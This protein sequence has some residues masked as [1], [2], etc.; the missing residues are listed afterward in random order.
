MNLLRPLHKISRH[1]GYLS[2]ETPFVIIGRRTCSCSTPL[3]LST[4]STP[5]RE[6][7]NSISNREPEPRPDHRAI[8]RQQSLFDT[9]VSS[10]GAPFFQPDGTHIFQKLTSFLRAQYPDFGFREV[11]TPTIYK[12]SLW[13][14]SGHWANYRDD[15]FK[16]TG[17]PSK[18][19]IAASLDFVNGHMQ[20][21]K[22]LPDDPELDQY[23]LKPMNCPGHCILFQ[24]KRR[25]YRDL[26]IRYA[27]FSPL[28]RNE[29]SGALSGLTRVRRFH[30]D[31][32]HI[33]CRPS[34]VM[35]EILGSIKFIKMIYKALHLYDY[36]FVLSTRPTS[37]YIG[38]VEEWDAAE[39]QLKQAL[40]SVPEILWKEN[41]GDGAFYGPKI[42]VNLR[43]SDGK[44]HQTATIQLDF[45]L[46]KRF[47]LEYDAPAPDS[48]AKG[49]LT[50]DSKLRNK[51]GKVTPVMIH[52]AVLGSLE[53][54]MALMLEEKD[55]RLPFW[56]SPRQV[57]V[58]TV[59]D[60][61]F[62]A[63]Y[64]QGVRQ[65]LSNVVMAPLSEDPTPRQLD[66][67]RYIVHMDASSDS[68]AQKIARAK[69]NKYNMI[70]IIGEKN[71]KSG[72]VDVTFHG[73]PNL[74]RTW[75]V[76]GEVEAGS[77]AFVQNDKATGGISRALGGVNLTMTQCR[78]IIERLSEEYL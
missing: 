26:P 13:E 36:R 76:V 5:S 9:H 62:I 15:M 61:D 31:D 77:Q 38:S 35:E 19:T 53:R 47:N 44:E 59:T 18:K 34:Q 1:N 41:R 7:K 52:R 68:I 67:P 48:E 27:E 8:G 75:T 54:F 49:D 10:P 3:G 17:N 6:E 25:S 72:T 11:I 20:R 73:Q 24:S 66:H 64:A 4:T 58:L 40:N 12:E 74:D 56:L 63:A 21:K 51:M 55:G 30:Q 37:D 65:I 43:D 23:G 22:D 46:P 33:F 60:R 32:G 28:H 78:K 2:T 39:D 70:C 71:V 42:D 45:Q 14:Q 16:V 29:I 69:Q 50:R 57:I